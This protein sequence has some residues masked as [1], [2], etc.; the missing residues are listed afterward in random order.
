MIENA[1]T[2]DRSNMEGDIRDSE[3]CSTQGSD[4]HSASDRSRSHSVESILTAK[5][6]ARNI[7]GLVHVLSDQ[8]KSLIKCITQRILDEVM[9]QHSTQL[10]AHLEHSI[11]LVVPGSVKS[12][13]SKKR[14]MVIMV[15][16]HMEPDQDEEIH[17]HV[18]L[19]INISNNLPDSVPPCPN[20]KESPADCQGEITV[21]VALPVTEAISIEMDG[22]GGIKIRSSQNVIQYIF[23]PVNLQ[24]LWVSYSYL[25][26]SIENARQ[27][28]LFPGSKNHHTWTGCYTAKLPDYLDSEDEWE[29][30]SQIEHQI[31]NHEFK[32]ENVKRLMEKMMFRMKDIIMT[33]DLDNASCLE[34]R[35]QLETEFHVNLTPYKRFIDEQIVKVFGQSSEPPDKIFDYLYLG[36]EWNASNLTELKKTGITHVLNVTMEIANFFSHEFVYKTIRIKDEEVSHL[37]QFWD[38]T[39]NFIKD[40]KRDNKKVFVHCR[41]GVSRSASCVIAYIMK[42]Y[43][44]NIKVA[45]DYVKKIRPCVNP[46][47]GFL[48]QLVEYNGILEARYNN[49]YGILAKRRLARCSQISEQKLITERWLKEYGYREE[50]MVAISDNQDGVEM[51]VHCAM[52]DRPIDG[53]EK[54][55]E[56]MKMNEL[57]G[58]SNSDPT[59]PINEDH[60]V[61]LPDLL[62][63]LKKAEESLSSEV[64]TSSSTLVPRKSFVHRSTD[65]TTDAIL[66]SHGDVT[67]TMTTQNSPL[68]DHLTEIRNSLRTRDS[69]ISYSV[70]SRALSCPQR[71]TACSREDLSSRDDVSSRDFISSREFTSRDIICPRAD[72]LSADGPFYPADLEY[73]VETIAEGVVGDCEIQSRVKEAVVHRIKSNPS[74]RRKTVGGGVVRSCVVQIEVRNEAESYKS[75]DRVKSMDNATIKRSKKI[76][77]T[78]SWTDYVTTNNIDS[79][80]K[81]KKEHKSKKDHAKLRH[82]GQKICASIKKIIERLLSPRPEK[83]NCKPSVNEEI[84]GIAEREGIGEEAS[85]GNRLPGNNSTN[86]RMS[87]PILQHSACVVIPKRRCKSGEF[88]AGGLRT[89]QIV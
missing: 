29:D 12:S 86:N 65:V 2:V 69:S 57:T 28:N 16:S 78:Q 71:A 26:C 81:P 14:Y 88:P 19:G 22:D 5:S 10:P 34:I 7:P 83:Q 73:E 31:G 39:Y 3:V 9:P 47:P 38:D 82:G 11:Q 48:K 18:I 13:D 51:E 74:F 45:Q 70:T 61:L 27:L 30:N 23:K 68:Y 63:Q 59:S 41:M 84:K 1:R 25:N 35:N 53:H 44:M 66:R 60:R 20:H 6:F 64:N 67:V 55:S 75:R 8:E 62:V 89:K 54:V 37:Q 80:T 52:I 85:A 4:V 24:A 72:D 21:A 79:S 77:Q 15:G 40:A 58:C 42:E 46:N 32:D 76:K 43:S 49:T 33:I 17:E 36:N 87:M 56:W 50:A